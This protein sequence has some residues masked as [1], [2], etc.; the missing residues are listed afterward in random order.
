[1]DNQERSTKKRKVAER[2]SKK[3]EPTTVAKSPV[4][5]KNTQ[6]KPANGPKSPKAKSEKSE[7][8]DKPLVETEKQDDVQEVAIAVS[9]VTLSTPKVFSDLNLTPEIQKTI[10]AIGYS[11]LKGIQSSAIPALLTDKD[12]S[13]SRS[14]L[15]HQF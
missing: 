6:K 4:G 13:F 9:D 15:K 8:T 1:M 10:S 3:P 2:D 5:K 14:L 11:E 12:V 7:K